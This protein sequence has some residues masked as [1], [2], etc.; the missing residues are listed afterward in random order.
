MIFTRGARRFA[1]AVAAVV[2]FAFLAP[3][4]AVIMGDYARPGEFPS[5]VAIADSAIYANE[6]SFTN[7]SFC[8]GVLIG[9]RLVLTAA[10]CVVE[11]PK[12]TMVPRINMPSELVVGGGV[13]SLD[14][15]KGAQVAHVLRIDPSGEY[16]FSLL[17]SNGNSSVDDVAILQIDATIPGAEPISLATAA[18]VAAAKAVPTQLHT[19]G[20]GD[21]SPQARG[22][23]IDALIKT[24]VTSVGDAQCSNP[25]STFSISS[26]D[27]LKSATFHGLNASDAAYFDSSTMLCA[28]GV[29]NNGD[30]TDT[31]LGDSGGP[32]ITTV[33]GI[34]TVVGVTS[35]GPIVGSQSCAL[36]EPSIYANAS[37]AR[38]LL[39]MYQAPTPT[40]V[41]TPTS[42]TI[43]A[44]RWDY[45]L[46]GWTFYV[47]DGVNT[48]GSC[49]AEPDPVTGV[50]TCTVT[51]LNP[52]SYYKVHAEPFTGRTSF[53]SKLILAQVQPVVPSNVK[54][55]GKVTKKILTKTT[56][57]I[58]LSLY[59]NSNRAVITR[60]T[61]TCISGKSKVVRASQTSSFT[62]PNLLRG[63]TYACAAT[64][65]NEMGTS[66][67]RKFVV[68]A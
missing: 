14:Q 37:R 68:V 34:E 48:S 33:D 7:A 32:L 15:M 51:G 23:Y 12:T 22:T 9:P 16:L 64:A 40:V 4:Q 55:L 43:T 2:S 62:V 58:S 30:V 56:A 50:A 10:H 42:F 41:T 39:E 5:I 46:G 49:V 18:D 1:A 66:L 21:L 19:A 57:R 63:K 17:S 20:W 44:K 45:N 67:P 36:D 31:C 26:P 47:V 11:Y 61:V 38:A 53:D 27:G 3:A 52:K 24:V 29:T 25:D 65:T 13:T 60:Y 8:A 35:W 54:I 6:G 28:I 59:A